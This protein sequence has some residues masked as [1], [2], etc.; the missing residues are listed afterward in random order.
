[1]SRSYPDEK[2]SFS[3]PRIMKM[4]GKGTLA[5][6]TCYDATFARIIDKTPIQLVLVG[7]SA[8]N[9]IYGLDSTL[10]VSIDEMV[11]H[12]RAVAAG[13]SKALLV[14]DMPFGSYQ[15]SAEIAI[16]NASKLLAAGAQAVKVEGGSPHIREI[17]GKLVE[18]G[19]PV[20]G[21]LGLT[22]QSVHKIG[23]YKLQGKKDADAELM[24]SEAGLL[25]EAGCFSI[26]LEKIP[27]ELAEK[28]T[29]AV[30]VPTIGIG[31]GPDCDGQILVLYDILGLDPEFKPRFVR[32]YAEL[33]QVIREA[34]E[35]YTE[36]VSRGKFPSE[37]ESF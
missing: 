10:P 28:I 27:A 11:M 13:L 9:V 2:K 16:T 30:S 29:S 35:R 36:D 3:V 22:P 19:I 12:T 18:V 4:K 34:L 24:L 31:A 6:I 25:E 32:R 15:P 17:I 14:A 20:M 21:H 1:M 37:E 26:V 33:E 8:A 7:D 5:T 23:G